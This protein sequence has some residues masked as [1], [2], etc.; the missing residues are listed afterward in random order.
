[1]TAAPA[2]ATSAKEVV[3]SASKIVGSITNK[4]M[5]NT[6]S[7]VGAVVGGLKGMLSRPKRGLREKVKKVF[8]TATQGRKLR[9][10]NS[11]ASHQ[12]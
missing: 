2:G 12:S 1:M 3:K 9:K 4:V 5:Q 6:N 10:Q 7:T 8:G 11:N